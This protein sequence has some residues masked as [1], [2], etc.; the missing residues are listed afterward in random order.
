MI[1]NTHQNQLKSQLIISPIYHHGQQISVMGF[2]NLP[3]H[4]AAAAAKVGS[5]AVII[6]ATSKRAARD[7]R[8]RLIAAPP[9]RRCAAV[10]PPGKR[11]LAL[12]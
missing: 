11:E 4:V 10:V 8:E 6:S 3:V 1:A 9:T 5:R 7:R 2:G 12:G